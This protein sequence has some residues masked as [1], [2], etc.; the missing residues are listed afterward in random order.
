MKWSLIMKSKIVFFLIFSMMLIGCSEINNNSTGDD[1]DNDRDEL[2]LA[3]GGEPDDG[4]DPTAGWGLYGSPLF[5]STSLSY[6]QDFNIVHDLAINY[7]VSVDGLIWTI[8]LR[9][10]VQF[11]DGEPLTS[12]DVVFTFE[13][14]KNSGSIIDLS[15]LDKVKAINGNTV[16]FTLKQPDSTFIHLLITTGIVPKHLYDEGYNEKPIGSGPYQLVQWDKG[17]QL[18]VEA[19]PYYY[20]HEPYFQKV[21]FLFLSEDAAFAA[22][23]AG[24]VDIASIP[25]TFAEETIPGMELV[26]VESVDNRGVMFPFVPSGEKTAEGY[27]IGNDVTSDIAIRKAINIGIDR[28]ALVEGVL[29]GYGTPAFT[30]ADKLPW[31]NP[32]TAFED[33]KIEAAKEIL[34]EAGWKV[35]EN[36]M[37]EKDG[38]LA[39]FSL[40]YPADDMTRQSLSMAFAEMVK[41]LGI[42]VETE[43]HSWNE[44]EKRMFSEPIMMGWGSH[45]PIEIY[46]LYSS[47]TKGIDYY[48]TNYYSNET[49]DNYLDKALR[50]TTQEEANT[51][52]KKAA[53]D[54]ETGYSVKG[55][56]PWAWLVNIDHLYLVNENLDIGEQKIQPH[57]HG[58][59]ITDFIQHWQWKN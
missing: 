33:N 37:R 9:E 18:I 39:S 36:G 3:I 40:L 27:P 26:N 53:W 19:N 30:I 11:S 38:M 48:N 1:P 17:Q 13:T 34:E 15:N 22:A 49:V 41:P 24:E 59:P 31:W 32:E 29:N 43:G 54:G 23:K 45:D 25:T 16:E 42:E 35:N 55:D 12:E 44:L 5:Q 50:A 28:N 46:N 2:V 14:T 6:D 20:G 58:W 4:F 52:W 57:G 56:A 51:F 21:T 47:K 8:E 10:D 7:D